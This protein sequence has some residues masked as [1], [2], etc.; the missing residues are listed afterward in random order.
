MGTR[1]EWDQ[2]T[3]LSS[4]SKIYDKEDRLERT[5]KRDNYLILKTLNY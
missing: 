3:G 5:Y 2:R 1:T 4:V